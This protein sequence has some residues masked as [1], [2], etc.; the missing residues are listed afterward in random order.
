MGQEKK[1][2]KQS[3]NKTD[4]MFI[5][6]D[7]NIDSGGGE[8]LEE[9]EE[10]FDKE[11]IDSHDWDIKSENDDLSKSSNGFIADERFPEKTSEEKNRQEM[12]KI[13]KLNRGEKKK[14]KREIRK[15]LLLD[16]LS[17]KENSLLYNFLSLLTFVLDFLFNFGTIVAVGVG[18]LFGIKYI[19]A[20]DWIM[21]LV[22]SAFVIVVAY[23]NERIK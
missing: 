6:E 13:Q 16:S 9:I 5:N 14:V 3:L 22:S 10:M 2:G 18:I 8:K 17:L 1:E 23:I 21:S 20:G 15:K 4:E 19:I 11:D 12:K 7:G